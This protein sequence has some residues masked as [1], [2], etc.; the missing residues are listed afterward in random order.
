MLCDF[1]SF[2]SKYIFEL[3]GN[4]SH[5]LEFCHRFWLSDLRFRARKKRPGIFWTRGN[6][7]PSV[8]ELR[9]SG[10]QIRKSRSRSLRDISFQK[11]IL[12][13]ILYLPP[14]TVDSETETMF[15]NLLAFERFHVG[16]GREVTNYLVFM[17]NIIR[18]MLVSFALMASFRML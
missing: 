7:I 1:Y 9:E 2:N 17:N 8:T 10:I 11:D 12:R 5:V 15:L 16:A 13:V 18:E 6:T 4:C 3:V 14:I